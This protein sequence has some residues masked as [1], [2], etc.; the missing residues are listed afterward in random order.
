MTSAV[1]KQ[2]LTTVNDDPLLDLTNLND[3]AEEEQ[4]PPLAAPKASSVTNQNLIKRS[5]FRSA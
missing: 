4:A 2:D 3:V 5:A 1:V